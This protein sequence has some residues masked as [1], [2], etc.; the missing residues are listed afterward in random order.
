MKANIVLQHNLSLLIAYNLNVGRVDSLFSIEN[1]YFLH[2]LFT[3]SQ[4][5][6]L[7]LFYLLTNDSFQELIFSG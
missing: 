2:L 5:N 7:S 6:T 4:I 3:V 1:F